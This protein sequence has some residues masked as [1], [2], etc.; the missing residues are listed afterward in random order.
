M[1]IFDLISLYIIYQLDLLTPGT[2]PFS[3]N[4]L[5]HIRHNSNLRI[6]ALCFP[7]LQQRVTFLVENLG[8]FLDFA[9]C[10]SIAIYIIFYLS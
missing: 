7:H 5:K 4:S 3:A 2:S 9:L 10:D 6:Y 1:F 8:V